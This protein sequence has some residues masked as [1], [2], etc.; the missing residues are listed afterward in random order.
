MLERSAPH[1]WIRSILPTTRAFNPLPTVLQPTGR[2]KDGKIRMYPSSSKTEHVPPRWGRRRSENRTVVGDIYSRRE[3]QPTTLTLAITTPLPPTSGAR[4]LPHSGANRRDLCYS[5][6]SS[7]V[8]VVSVDAGV[9]QRRSRE[10]TRSSEWWKNRWWDRVTPKEETAEREREGREGGRVGWTKGSLVG[11]NPENVSDEDG[12]TCYSQDAQNVRVGRE[13]RVSLSLS[14]LLS[15]RIAPSL[16]L[17][18][19]FLTSTLLVERQRN[20]SMA[21]RE[22]AYYAAKR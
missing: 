18:I 9:A 6:R 11:A 17:S 3:G 21:G 4:F 15:L 1:S 12:A 2:D 8:S 14:L 10:T 16:F 5:P 7:D 20:S 19:I 22:P 13:E